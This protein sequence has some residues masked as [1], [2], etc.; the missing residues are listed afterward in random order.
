MRL[1]SDILYRTARRFPS[2]PALSD[3]NQALDYRD[4]ARCA[5]GVAHALRKAGLVPGDR[6]CLLLP[7]SVEFV[8]AHFGVLSAGGVSVPCEPSIGR[9][10]LEAIERDCAPRFVLRP[11]ALEAGG[12]IEPRDEPPD[13]GC[14]AGDVATLMYTTGTTGRPKGVMLRHEN[15]LAALRNISGFIGYTPEDKEVV[16]LPLS[17]NFGLGHLY[18][19]LMNGCEVHVE[20]GLTRIG[21]LLR[22]IEAMPATGFPT[23]PAGI[24]MLLDR[25]GA[26]F[27]SHARALRFVVID[28]AP[29][30]PER[31]VQ[32]R[33]ALP[34]TRILVYY[35]LTEA[36]RSTFIDFNA[37]GPGKYR[38]V[39]KP[40]PGIEMR[41]SDAGEI[42]I[43]GPTVTPGYWNDPART[44][45]ALREGW[46]HSGDLGR[47]DSD[48]YLEVVGRLEEVV[49]VGGYKV[50]PQEVEGV[51]AQFPGVSAAGVFGH[52]RVEAAIVCSTPVELEDL[53]RHCRAHLE[54]Y[55]VP[56][57]IHRVAT[58]PRTETG[59]LLRRNL[60]ARFAVAETGPVLETPTSEKVPC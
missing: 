40:M 31:V 47:F 55:K 35:G 59:K 7:N 21:R 15:V 44:A 17:H 3:P 36:S 52:N 5:A 54:P 57:A 6:V 20:P 10:N 51:L 1:L 18:C 56:T 32:L 42:L 13:P 33:A 14:Q 22:K 41:L 9:A 48:G 2:R 46:L 28:S 30:A 49:N 45:Q 50:N 4:L 58:L 26:A 38:S 24:D 12:W 43:R 25:Y 53:V 16:A 11:G 27:A 34:R 8:V 29:L 39:G 19:N 60:A 37:A 23:T